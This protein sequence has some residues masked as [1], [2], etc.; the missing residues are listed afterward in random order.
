MWS[1]PSPDSKSEVDLPSSS[2]VIA[3][4]EGMFAHGIATCGGKA[5]LRPL[6]VAVVSHRC[7]L[8]QS[9]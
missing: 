9:N 4:N 8:L 5:T 7:F 2:P 1:M 3:V 6:C